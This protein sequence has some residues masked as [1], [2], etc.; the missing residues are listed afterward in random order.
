VPDLDKVLAETADN[1]TPKF[2]EVTDPDG[3]AYSLRVR[4]YRTEDN[5]IDGLVM[6][7]IDVDPVMRVS[8]WKSKLPGP[9]EPVGFDAGVSLLVAQEDERRRLARELHDELSQRFALLEYTVQNLEIQKDPEA[10]F[11][12]L[13]EFQKIVSGLSEDLRRVAYQ[14]H[15]AIVEDL[16]LV[17]ALQAYC[18]DFSTREHI[19]VRFTHQNIPADLPPQVA[20]TLYRVAQEGL[21]NVAKHSG[22]K[23]AGVSLTCDGRRLDLVIRDAGNGF[24]VG[25]AQT[26][27]GMV[28]MRERI[29]LI[30]GTI[31]W[32]TKPGDGTQVVVSVPIT[33]D[34]PAT[35]PAGAPGGVSNDAT[36]HSVG[37]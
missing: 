31:E 22:A 14:L 23:Q 21:R 1:L 34:A 26:G 30:G 10:T 20:I 15:P 4:P 13:K 2:L 16:G 5:K 7:F 25:Q 8:D 37:G 3:R 36:T 6:V 18:D 28:G 29:N 27:L 12:R 32:K 11:K 33:I 24:R 19:V 17:P 35:N 9:Q